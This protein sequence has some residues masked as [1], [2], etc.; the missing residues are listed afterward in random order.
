MGTASKIASGKV[1]TAA[2]S[3]Q[4]LGAIRLVAGRRLH[5]VDPRT[6][7]KSALETRSQALSAISSHAVNDVGKFVTRV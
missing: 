1:E 7:R 3:L 6:P 2:G 4:M 5:L